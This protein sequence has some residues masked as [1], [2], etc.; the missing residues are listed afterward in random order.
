M[1][2]DLYPKFRNKSGTLTPY[3]FACGYIE[4]RGGCSL[5]K[6]GCWHVKT[7]GKW[8]CFDTLKEARAFFN[9]AARTANKTRPR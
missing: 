8:E 4:T 3:A 2:T 7:P 1:T 6:D 5:Y 9:R